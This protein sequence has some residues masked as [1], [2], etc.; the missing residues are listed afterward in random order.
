MGKLRATTVD[1][2]QLAAAKLKA[3][4][5]P[6]LPDCLGR[7]ANMSVVVLNPNEPETELP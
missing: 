7:S 6:D 1:D 2:C 4:A 5:N 3:Q